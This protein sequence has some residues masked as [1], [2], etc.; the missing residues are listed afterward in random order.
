[1][2]LPPIIVQFR[3]FFRYLGFYR[4]AR[5]RYD[6]DS[7][8]VSTFIEEVLEDKRQFYAFS[9]VKWVRRQLLR[10]SRQLHINDHGA[11]SMVVRSNSRS[12]RHIARHGAIGD[13]QGR[14]LFR[15]AHYYH[16]QLIV[17]LGTSLGIS[18]LYLALADRRQQ[19]ISV[20]GSREIASRAAETFYQLRLQNI[21]LMQ[22]TF[23]EALAI[24]LK[25]NPQFDLVY[26]DGD[27]RKGS[28]IR[29]FNKMLPT[30][31]QKSILIIADI[32]WSEEMQ[33][34]WQ[35]IKGHPK[36]SIAIDLFDFG[37]LFFD[38]GIREKLDLKL[39]PA[40]LKPWRIGLFR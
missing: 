2:Q 34:A 24:L 33:S 8:F 18:T 27:H 28:S 25:E 31:H 10:E 11:G 12:V 35:Q 40:R 6:I 15:I 13:R 36:V 9:L 29:Y 22:Q 20:E 23:D 37:V 17:E 30:F 19:V 32:Y 3:L 14:Y 1:M 4:K 21:S 39:V 5:T 16:P 26:L 7:P 38:P